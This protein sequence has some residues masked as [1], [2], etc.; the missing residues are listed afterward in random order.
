MDAMLSHRPGH[1]KMPRLDAYLRLTPL[2]KPCLALGRLA[3]FSS[4]VIESSGRQTLC[5][6]PGFLGSGT[7]HQALYLRRGIAGGHAQVAQDLASVGTAQPRVA[8]AAHHIANVP[9]AH[10]VVTV[11]Q[12]LHIARALQKLPH[13]LDRADLGLVH[14]DHHRWMIDHLHRT[15]IG[16][17]NPSAQDHSSL[18]SRPRVQDHTSLDK[19]TARRSA[20]SVLQ[21]DTS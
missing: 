14:I 12:E 15:R 8:Q 6:R 13:L 17:P 18:E 19:T 1:L 16:R 9:V 21:D 7:G 3:S 10:L 4:G 11:G 2:R 5:T 20:R